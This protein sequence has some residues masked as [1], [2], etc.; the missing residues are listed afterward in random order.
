MSAH[1][2]SRPTKYLCCYTSG[3]TGGRLLHTV[4]SFVCL[5]AELEGLTE[6]TLAADWWSLG[7][8][9]FEILTGQV[10]GLH[11]LLS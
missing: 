11:L 1:M 10:M 2:Y 3:W 9:L 5:C 8:I 6:P 7:A 4:L